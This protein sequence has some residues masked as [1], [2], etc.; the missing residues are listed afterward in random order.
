MSEWISDY[1]EGCFIDSLDTMNTWCI[2]KIVSINKQL[3][4][5]TVRYDGWSEK[6]N[7]SCSFISN[8]IAPFRKKSE[9]YT[10]QKGLAIRDWQFNL[11][12]LLQIE[13]KLNNLPTTSFHLT[14]LLRGHLFTLV[15]CLLVWEYKQSSDLEASVRF[16]MNVLNF[17]V[18]WMKTLQNSFQFYYETLSNPDL[19]LTNSSAALV[20]SFPELLFTLRR[21]FGLDLRTARHL[22]T[23]TIVP[24]EYE[25][26]SDIKYKK[27]STI[28]FFINYFTKIG[29]FNAI[30]DL[31]EYKK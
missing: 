8:R 26:S 7:L 1:D 27:N 17:L 6:W 25:F 13:E 3:K 15:D 21:L 30:L 14:Q 29:G 31:L 23:W 22:N 12:E 10:G 11:K 4:W 28:L 16:L 20:C 18:N 5:V 24:K 2:G 19:F 9:L